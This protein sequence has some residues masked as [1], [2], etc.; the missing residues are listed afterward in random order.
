VVTWKGDPDLRH[1][2]GS[3]VTL[4]FQMRNAELYSIRFA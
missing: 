3:P 4:C 2:E 1:P